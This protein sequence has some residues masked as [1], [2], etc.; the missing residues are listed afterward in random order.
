MISRVDI[1]DYVASAVDTVQ[2]PVYC[3]ARLEVAPESFPACY[4]V[5][6][7]SAS[8]EWNYTL[9]FADQQVRRDFEVQVFSNL[10]DGALAEAE[11]IMDDVRAAFRRLYFIE[12]YVGRTD[13][14][15]PTVVRI[16]GRFH[17]VIGASDKMP[18]A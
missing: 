9:D 5:E 15:D 6:T 4:I 12:N 8:Q 13:N 17:R 14:V 18:T 3:E 2:R 16:V 10:M 1:Y 11:S 7:D